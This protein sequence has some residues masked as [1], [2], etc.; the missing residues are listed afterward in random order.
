[1]SLDAGALKK[2]VADLE[3][4]SIEEEILQKNAGL[5][6]TISEG[7]AQLD[8]LP[9]PPETEPFF[10]RSTVHKTESKKESD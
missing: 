5:L 6:I 1:M 7:V 2:L 8:N 9:I 3:K 4:I 10:S